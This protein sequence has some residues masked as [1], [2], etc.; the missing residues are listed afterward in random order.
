MDSAS[1]DRFVQR[2]AWTA[3][4]ANALEVPAVITVERPERNGGPAQAVMSAQ[5]T[6]PVFEKRVFALAAD[7]PILLA[8]ESLRRGTAVLVGMETDVCAA[9]SAIG[10]RDLGYRVVVVTDAVY[11]PGVAHEQG[12]ARMLQADV[13]LVSAKAL[14]YEWLRDVDAVRDLKT[15][16]PD[17]AQPPGFLL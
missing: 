8:V 15:R 9:Q 16:R 4:L 3:R 11:S 17:I 6:T 2:V 14:F 7:L 1:F 12:L 10:L 5:P 13:E